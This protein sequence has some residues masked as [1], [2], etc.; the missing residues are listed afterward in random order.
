M[1]RVRMELRFKTLSGKVALFSVLVAVTVIANL[2]MV[3]MPYPLAE[4]DL[5]PVLIYTIGVLVNPPL[6]GVI[7]AVAMALG[8]GY[9]MVVFGF[10]PVFVIGAMVVRGVEASLI[11]FIVRMKGPTDAKTVSKWEVVAMVV[12][13]VWETVG[14]F[15]ADWYLFGLGF[16]MTVLLTIVDAVFIPVAVGVIAAVR[17]RLSM[18]RLI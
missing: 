5:S 2:I 8:V 12:G 15:L 7:I 16:A 10:P 6:A 18:Q 9:K 11:S 3:P 1:E 17:Q 4:Y 13:A 14:F